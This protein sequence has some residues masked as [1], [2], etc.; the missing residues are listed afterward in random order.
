MRTLL[1]FCTILMFGANSGPVSYPP[2]FGDCSLMPGNSW[3]YNSGDQ[4][5]F[6][7]EEAANIYLR[8]QHE[9]LNKRYRYIPS[10]QISKISKIPGKTPDAAYIR[11]NLS[12]TATVELK[13]EIY[14]HIKSKINPYVIETNIEPACIE[15]FSMIHPL[16]SYEQNDLGGMAGNIY[17]LAFEVPAESAHEIMDD[18]KQNSIDFRVSC[19]MRYPEQ[20]Q[21]DFTGIRELISNAKRDFYSP[22]TCKDK[23]YEITALQ[24]KLVENFL[25]REIKS[26]IIFDGQPD[27]NS[28][29]IVDLMIGHLFKTAAEKV[30]SFE[31]IKADGM[32]I[33]FNGNRYAPDFVKKMAVDA[34]EMEQHDFYKKYK[35]TFNQFKKKGKD[36][37]HSGGFN[38]MSIIGGSSNFHYKSNSEDSLKKTLDDEKQTKDL[39][40]SSF[41]YEEEGGRWIPKGIIAYE[42]IQSDS[43]ENILNEL[44]IITLR[45]KYQSI[46]V[47]IIAQ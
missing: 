5:V 30:I 45:K 6:I 40:E 16:G 26:R 18:I 28:Q 11:M 24:K 20:H 37:G 39:I 25:R 27:E 38:V 19:L 1:L 42:N 3:T 46:P 35:T 23:T 21:L 32:L 9:L 4:T 17:R 14:N 41:K 34:R 47:K 10:F 31:D 7:Y 8:K 29:K 33:D 36:F 43:K 15:G 12:A 44:D 22:V 13:S 2:L